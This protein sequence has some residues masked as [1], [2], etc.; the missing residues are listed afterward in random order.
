MRARSLCGRPG[1]RAADAG[2]PG[3]WDCRITICAATVAGHAP[4]GDRHHYTRSSSSARP[5]LTLQYAF[6]GCGTRS[7]SRSAVERTTNMRRTFCAA[8]LLTAGLTLPGAAQQPT[9]R[10][11]DSLAMQIRVLRTKLDSVLALLAGP[12]P[13][14]PAPPSPPGDD[15]AA[16]RAA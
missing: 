12:R 15:P 10:Q 4:I 14:A 6:R 8:V 1:R 5:L 7:T 2:R 9:Q 13:I 3:R 11:V 16:F